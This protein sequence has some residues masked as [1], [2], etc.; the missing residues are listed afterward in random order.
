MKRFVPWI[1]GMLIGGMVSGIVG[2]V[3]VIG[4]AVVASDKILDNGFS[5]I[6]VSWGAPRG[7]E[8]PLIYQARVSTADRNGDG[9][10]EVRAVVYI[11]SGMHQQDMGVIGTARGHDAAVERFGRITWTDSE[12]QIGGSD[13]IQARLSRSG[14]ESHR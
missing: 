2:L 1:L 14:L 5:I 12:L 6:A 11:A 9:T 3:L 10:L 4:G 13:G 8:R 7:Q